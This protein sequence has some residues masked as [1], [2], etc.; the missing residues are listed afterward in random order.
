MGKSRNDND[1]NID[2]PPL[3]EE[4]KKI[5]IHNISVCFSNIGINKMNLNNIEE[6]NSA[7][8][9]FNKSIENE[10][11]IQGIEFIN[12]CEVRIKKCYSYIEYLESKNLENPIDKL[13]KINNAIDK[14][15]EKEN[16]V[17]ELFLKSKRIQLF[18][19][20]VKNFNNKNYEEAK[21]Y[22]QELLE[23]KLSEDDV[24]LTQ[25]A[26]NYMNLSEAYIY[27]NKG[28]KNFEERNFKTALEDIEKA[29]ISAEKADDMNL[30]ELFK[31]FKEQIES[32]I[33]KNKN[34]DSGNEK[35]ILKEI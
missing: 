4:N 29:I 2:N 16:G 30:I 20:G 5:I 26:T 19:I 6:F 15:P 17:N 22:F 3:D 8:E 1:E 35:K 34:N 32:S 28:N 14:W 12:E 9:Y 33:E 10:K 27:Y 25:K 18:N 7:I 23:I 11:E 13:S 21:Q 31:N 24:E